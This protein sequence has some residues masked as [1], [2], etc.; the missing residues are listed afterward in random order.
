MSPSSKPEKLALKVFSSL[1]VYYSP[2]GRRVNLGFYLKGKETE[3]RRR[4]ITAFSKIN[5]G[6]SAWMVH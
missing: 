6:K 4:A 5:S 2:F 1:V 3:L